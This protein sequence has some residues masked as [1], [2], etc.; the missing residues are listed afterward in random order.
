[1]QRYDAHFVH[2]GTLTALSVGPVPALTM[3]SWLGL[4]RGGG[5]DSYILPQTQSQTGDWA[6][7]RG[8]GSHS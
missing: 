5:G 3:T 6:S 1:M 4:G 2:C 8:K 7:G